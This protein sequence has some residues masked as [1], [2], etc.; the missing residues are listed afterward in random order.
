MFEVSA[1]SIDG[2]LGNETLSHLPGS[3]SYVIELRKLLNNLI[4][5]IDNPVNQ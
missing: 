4:K 2:A 3:F 5:A 1:R